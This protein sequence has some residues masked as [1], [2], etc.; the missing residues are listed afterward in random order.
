MKGFL[1]FTVIISL[2]AMNISS[3]VQE[4][5]D[6]IIKIVG[7]EEYDRLMNLSQDK[8]D[9][10]A[11]G[12]RQYSDNY[13]LICLLIPKYI[14]VNKL[15]A[16]QSRN[17]HWHLGQMHAFKANYKDAIAEM[18]QSY[19]GG[20]ITWASYVSGSIAFLEKDKAT[21]IEALET[22]QKQD[23]QM[24]IEFLEKFVKYFDKPYSEAY[25]GA[26]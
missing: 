20:S 8:F 7:S 26:Y 1:F 2:F 24:N 23:N 10:S 14:K 12:F 25:N 22:L 3:C 5:K 15:S 9:Q 19:E 18:K 11:E 6:E 17:L 4:A 13:E 21:L 16:H